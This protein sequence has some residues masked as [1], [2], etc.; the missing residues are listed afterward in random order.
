VEVRT[1]IAGV[2]AV[3]VA[4]TVKSYAVDLADQTRQ[5]PEI[6]LGAS[7][8]ATLQLVRAAKAWAALEGRGYVVPDD[9]QRLLQPVV[10]HRLL[11]TA[12][13]HVAGRSAAQVLDRIVA[14]TPIPVAAPVNGRH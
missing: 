13:A 12:E 2:A 1:L 6:R 5:A 4:A 9:V 10:A 14:T 7:P 8:R 11:L 3:H